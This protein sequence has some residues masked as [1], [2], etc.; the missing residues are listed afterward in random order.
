MKKK[1]IDCNG[2]KLLIITLNK[3]E[4]FLYGLMFWK[5]KKFKFKEGTIL[6]KK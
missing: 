4:M 1:A 6:I 3:I 5:Y 2:E